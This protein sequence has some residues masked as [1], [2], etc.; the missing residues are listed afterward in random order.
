[1]RQKNITIKLRF[2]NIDFWYI[3]QIGKSARI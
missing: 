2:H 3:S 1:M